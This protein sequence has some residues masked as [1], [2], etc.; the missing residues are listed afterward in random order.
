MR[1]RT[2]AAAPPAAARA[3]G[4]AALEQLPQHEGK[5]AAVLV[6]LDLLGGVDPHPRGELLVAR[7]HG[8]LLGLAVA[9]PDDRELLLAGEA[10]RFDRVAVGELERQD[11]HADEVGAVDP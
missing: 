10:E 6:V 7:T 2:L 4:A 5:D 11:P 8:D 3:S 9:D 1:R